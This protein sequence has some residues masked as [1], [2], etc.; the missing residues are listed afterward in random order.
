MATP[1]VRISEGQMTAFV[2][3]C[4]DYGQALF[5]PIDPILNPRDLL[6]SVWD[7]AFE[8]CQDLGINFRDKSSLKRRMH[9]WR[10]ALKNHHDD[11]KSTGIEMHLTEEEMILHNLWFENGLNQ[12]FGNLNI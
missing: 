9:H 8:K 6:N 2:S 11:S 3:W 7:S 10:R 12:R 4:R 1:Y 5:D